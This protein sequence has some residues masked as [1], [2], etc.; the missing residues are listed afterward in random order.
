MTTYIIRRLLLM[1]PTLIGITFL[2]FM[3]VASAP[4]GIGAAIQAQAGGS[5]QANSAVAIQAA[6]LE[7]RY[8]LKDPKILQYL[9]WLSRISPIK[10][11]TRDQVLPNGEVIRSPRAIPDP[12][13][14]NW[15]ATALPAAET[16]TDLDIPP[17]DD[18]DG[19][20]RLHRQLERRYI[21]ARFNAI[22]ANT[23][24][25]SALVTYLRA[26]NRADAIDKDIRVRP[27]VVRG[28]TPDKMIAEWGAVETAGVA[29]VE[30]FE[31]AQNAHARFLAFFQ[32][33]PFRQYGLG[34][35]PGVL[36]IGLP[37]FGTAFTS[38]R[39]VISLIAA[40]LPVT[41]TLNLIA[42]PIIYLVA[43][44]SGI[45]ASVRK[46][47]WFDYGLGTLYI[48]LYSFPVVL[49]GVLFIGFLAN[50][51]YL[52]W[53]PVAGLNSMEA[54]SYRFLPTF[55]PSF[56][57]GWLLDRIWHI[58]LPVTCLVYGGFAV[59]SKQTRAAMLENFN[60]D[61][62][63]TAKA[64]GVPGRAV[65]FRH[66][67]R[68]SLLPLITIFVTVF[69]AML[70]GSIVI[71]KIFT[72]PGMG[73]LLIEAINLRDAEVILGNTVMIACVNLLALLLAD[74]LY[75]LADPRVVYN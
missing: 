39:P 22:A 52:G 26:V 35:I 25:N 37:D 36:S 67:F 40:A 74:I 4:G 34:I 29:A 70:A 8:G 49:A 63:R 46:D 57:P 54:A 56:Q 15:F 72:I 69:P 20:V 30:A 42:I 47:S 17:S 68:N 5:F 11:G 27:E 50:K 2:V 64:K 38:S 1:I 14:W 9:R 32:A 48:G 24:L 31:K 28:M 59:L 66:V 58:C 23:N 6:A 18:V 51:D 41:I 71:E 73:S 19:R 7:D 61:Y 53:F 55:S 13:A 21:E 44:P 65:V 3:L 62:V 16:V 43:I 33:K 75:A 12:L 60:A 45:L 10:F